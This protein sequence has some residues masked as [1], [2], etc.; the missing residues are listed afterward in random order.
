MVMSYLGER[1]SSKAILA[2][3]KL[4]VDYFLPQSIL[5]VIEA[6]L[7]IGTDIYFTMSGVSLKSQLLS[8]QNQEELLVAKKIAVKIPLRTALGNGGGIDIR[9]DGLEL[10]L[11]HF[12]N[13][14]NDLRLKFL[15]NEELVAFFESYSMQLKVENG[16]YHVNKT[17]N[18]IT[19][20][21]IPNL[22]IRNLSL[23]GLSAFELQN[24]ELKL[25]LPYDQLVLKGLFVG[26]FY[27]KEV[28]EQNGTKVTISARL[29]S[30]G[31]EN[32]GWQK[33]E[34]QAAVS[35]ELL[36]FQLINFNGRLS[37]DDESQV[38]IEKKEQEWKYSSEFPLQDIFSL[39][40]FKSSIRDVN[41]SFVKFDGSLF[42]DF[43][44]KFNIPKLTQINMF[45]LSSRFLV[46]GAW[47]GIQLG[48]QAKIEGSGG[49]IHTAVS[50]PFSW[51]NFFNKTFDYAASTPEL[52][53]A[54]I[55]ISIKKSD[56]FK[57]IQRWKDI[58]SSFGGGKIPYRAKGGILIEKVKVDG[59][60]INGAFSHLVENDQHN[61]NLTLKVN[62]GEMNFNFMTAPKKQNSRKFSLKTEVREMDIEGL[63]LFLG[64]EPVLTK[65]E[66][67]GQLQLSGS[68][69]L[70]KKI[71]MVGKKSMLDFSIT[72]GAFRDMAFLNFSRDVVKNVEMLSIVKL[73]PYG[74]DFDKINIKADILN[75]QLRVRSFSVDG[76]MNQ[77]RMEVKGNIYFP[78][79][80]QSFFD[81]TV[82]EQKQGRLTGE[83][84]DRSNTFTPLLK[85]IYHKDSIPIQIIGHGLKLNVDPL[86]TIKL[87]GK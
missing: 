11:D 50:L 86:Y 27:F 31:L 28:L 14:W 40:G 58:L 49:K 63:R 26:D 22:L 74:K 23:K 81:F 73:L 29:G 68:M 51:G 67:S 43:N 1:L 16:V 70:D 7:D 72:K 33:N 12:I 75:H 46:D 42:P 56:L 13:I 65:G 55:D 10:K 69:N 59:V 71:T 21:D 83:F 53:L 17:W 30:I 41:R 82:D 32:L 38:L 45:D 24:S 77:Y 57:E 19:K 47:D 60:L 52:N 25:Q 87:L 44:L 79:N 37:F 85:K 9:I 4:H 66:L 5:D 62:Q 80:W 3:V 34:V 61:S 64:H 48:L 36:H 8:S 54:L 78:Q 2:H 18:N 20:L 35:M 76:G 6:D 39:F 84:T 15:A